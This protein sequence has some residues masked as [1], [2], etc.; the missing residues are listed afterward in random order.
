[1][2]SS[3]DRQA[4]RYFRQSDLLP[5]EL[6][7][8]HPVTVVG[9]GAIGRQVALQLAVMGVSPL[10]LIDPDLVET[11]NLG[12]QG[13][14]EADLGTLK[15]DATARLIGQLNP[16]VEVVTH[17]RRFRRSTDAAEVVLCCVDS[18]D[19][20]GHIFEAVKETAR[21]FIDGR[22]SAE[23]LRVLT[24][25]DAA[26]LAHYPRTLF[27][28]EEAYQGACTA[29]TTYYGATIAAGLM[30]ARLAR[31]LRGLAVPGDIMLNLLA[32]E[33]VVRDIRA[34]GEARHAV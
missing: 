3:I 1:M 34:D 22:M 10:T 20:R 11:V 5:Q 12:A 4:D 33:L 18:I 6:L 19:T 29:R 21:F 32:D 9:V 15:V 7:R 16:D 17:G 24:V 31:W 28:S 26:T 8:R 23:A 14:L 30:V 13:F 27:R 25:S 2:N